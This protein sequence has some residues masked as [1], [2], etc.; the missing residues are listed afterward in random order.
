MS[1]KQKLMHHNNLEP[2]CKNE[3]HNLVK[4]IG[5]F[6]R[7]LFSLYKT[8]NLTEEDLLKDNDYIS[9]KEKYAETEQKLLDSDFFY[10]TLG[11]NFSDYPKV[12]D[13]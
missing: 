2:E 11:E 8:Y 4:L 12:L 5:Y 7:C 3:R 9:L 10:Y 6:K 1:K 13:D